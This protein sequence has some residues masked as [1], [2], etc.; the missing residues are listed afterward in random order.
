MSLRT[1]DP[2]RLGSRGTPV[3]RQRLYQMR[4][5]AEGR[6]QQCGNQGVT[7][8]RCSYCAECWEKIREGNRKR[9]GYTDEVTPGIGRPR[10]PLK[11]EPQTGAMTNNG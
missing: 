7:S 3:S 10:M 8:G 4:R 9:K 2:E 6:C 5:A 11:A 1:F